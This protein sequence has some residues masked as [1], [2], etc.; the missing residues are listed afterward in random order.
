MRTLA[1]TLAIMHLALVTAP[2]RADA[3]PA[4]PGEA[5]PEEP[6]ELSAGSYA[7]FDVHTKMVLVGQKIDRPMHPASLTKLMTLLLA[8]E[9]GRP[10]ERVRVSSRAAATGGSAMGL[11]AGEK[12]SLQSLMVGLMLPSG[13]DAAVALAEHLGGDVAN[14][15]RLM[16]RRAEDLGMKNT[17]FVNPHGLTEPGHRSTAH[18]LAALTAAVLQIPALRALAA[19]RSERVT[20]LDGRTVQLTNTN[21]LLREDPACKGVKTGTTSAAGPCLIAMG[22]SD[23]RELAAVI[24]RSDDRYGDAR[25]LLEWGFA[26]F[27]WKTLVRSDRPA[28]SVVLRDSSDRQVGLAPER[29][30]VLP[31]PA[32]PGGAAHPQLHITHPVQICAP[33]PAPVGE[34][35]LTFQG[36]R[37]HA[38][39]LYCRVQSPPNSRLTGT[40]R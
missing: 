21:R 13:N 5:F 33:S 16:Q 24:L 26:H 39:P 18:D 15:A 29:D 17:R 30:L 36:E 10:D 28:A 38:V 35:V 7:L 14:F 3:G 20:S 34:L 8:W 25:R 22:R 1:F 11:R 4:F 23:G 32:G 37:I 12:W 2:S 9:L 19:L 27:T 40:S 31:V 6:P